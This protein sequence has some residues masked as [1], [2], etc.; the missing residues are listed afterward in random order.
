M[1]RTRALKALVLV[2]ALA[3]LFEAAV[4][5]STKSAS[6]N[7]SAARQNKSKNSSSKNKNKNTSSK[8]NKK[9]QS[10]RKTSSTSGTTSTSMTP[11][12]NQCD[13]YDCPGHENSI[14]VCENSPKFTCEEPSVYCKIDMPQDQTTNDTCDGDT[15]IVADSPTGIEVYKLDG[16]NATN[17]TDSAFAADSLVYVKAGPGYCP[18]SVP[19]LGP[20]I[21]PAGPNGAIKTLSHISFCY[22]CVPTSIAFYNGTKVVTDADFPDKD[23]LVCEDAPLITLTAKDNCGKTVHVERT[24]TGPGTVN[25]DVITKGTCGVYTVTYT[26]TSGSVPAPPIL[27][28]TPISYTITMADGDVSETESGP[29]QGAA[30]CSKTYTTEC[31]T[32]GT[33]VPPFGPL[34][35][36]EC[37][38]TANFQGTDFCGKTIP[39]KSE[40]I[41]IGDCYEQEQKK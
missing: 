16:G 15:L 23:H 1:T 32:N 18:Y 17:I 34:E 33:T 26:A 19:L 21:A 40:T 25:G 38:V 22:R 6:K 11:P 39:L 13:G 4:A 31:S 24:V 28:A 20:L 37:K 35:T 12:R 5:A 10:S 27:T 8:N 7:K 29:P 41:S 14:F 2:L 30:I 3:V 9:T 36:A